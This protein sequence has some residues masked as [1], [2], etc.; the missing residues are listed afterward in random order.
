MSAKKERSNPI[1][2]KHPMR[3]ASPVT[4]LLGGT[5]QAG[6][7][8]QVLLSD[9]RPRPGQPRR[10]FDPE[11][12]EAL[13]TSVREQGV[14]QPLLVREVQGG[15]E[16]VAGERRYRA[17]LEAGLSRVPVIIRRLSDEEA[18]LIALTENLQRE[19]LNPLEETEGVLGLL[20]L[21]LEQP[22]EDVVTLL[23]RMDNEAKG[24]ATHNVMGK[25]DAV[26]VEET[27]N[28]LS[29]GTWQSFV[30]NRLPLL[31]L[32][33]DVLEV[34]R[35]GRLD[36]TKARAIARLRDARARARLLQRAV[37]EGLSLSQ[38]RQEVGR[39][40]A[41]PQPEPDHYGERVKALGR[42]LARRE[43]DEERRKRVD[44]LLSELERLLQA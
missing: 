18:Q 33:E 39:L 29:R 26:L 14:L 8:T 12:M 5:S 44:E 11:A 9:L 25:P 24:K 7:P 16:I 38:I 19:D 15:Y 32:P 36:Y 22:V 21:R 20:A 6:T 2:A 31:K 13:V 30:A 37:Q 40:A 23:Y 17:A 3:N 41:K 34:I 43:L 4:A 35:S 1:L 28:S 10:Y 27:F 42:A